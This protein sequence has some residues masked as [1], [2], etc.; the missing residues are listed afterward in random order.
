MGTARRS[1]WWTRGKLAAL[2]AVFAAAS[3]VG[4]ALLRDDEFWLSILAGLGTTL[5]VAI[6][7]FYAE[8]V[9]EKVVEKQ[10][11][12]ATEDLGG[13][14]D[15]VQTRVDER[16]DEVQAA[17]NERVDDLSRRIEERRAQDDAE[18]LREARGVL[19]DGSFVSVLDA[20]KAGVAKT[21]IATTV[22]VPMRED[23]LTISFG[24]NDEND[25]IAVAAIRDGRKGPRVPYLWSEGESFDDMLVSLD[26]EVI[27]EWGAPGPSEDAWRH[28]KTAFAEALELAAQRRRERGKDP[29]RHP[30]MELPRQHWLITLDRSILI[31]EHRNRP[32]VRFPASTVVGSSGRAPDIDVPDADELPYAWSAAYWR[33]TEDN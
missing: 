5:A 4:A 11:T 2:I 6:P 32:G 12:K 13:Q 29:E 24:A 16:V 8:D 21:E 19:Q 30:L 18:A 7:L 28:M 9:F 23:E 33:I 14:I 3:L 1:G 31:L 27:D 20:L 22:F 26:A 25:G 15:Q 10:V 17:V